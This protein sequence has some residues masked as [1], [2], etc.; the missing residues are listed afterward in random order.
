MLTEDYIHTGSILASSSAPARLATFLN[1]HGQSEALVVFEV[2]ELCHLQREPLSS[3]GWNFCGID[4]E[5]DRI[6]AA[7][8][9][10]VWM[11]THEQEVWMTNTGHWNS[12][13]EAPGGEL[14]ISAGNDGT[15][16]AMANRDRNF[17]LFT[18]DV[19]SASFIDQGIVLN[20]YARGGIP[21]SLWPL[22]DGKL[23]PTA[24]IHGAKSM[25]R[26]PRQISGRETWNPRFH[27]YTLKH[28]LK[29]RSHCDIGLRR[30]LRGFVSECWMPQN[31]QVVL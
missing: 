27:S 6:I 5:V 13:G 10:S 21:D 12:I 9:G 7:D 30:H 23:L 19:A 20:R 11:I 31:E 18:F 8:R 24:M 28:L 26:L 25:R 22:A 17:H 3:S 15:I 29:T 4:A 16:Y 14:T 1:G 2:G